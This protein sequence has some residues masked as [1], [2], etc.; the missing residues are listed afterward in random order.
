MKV[1]L[2]QVYPQLMYVRETMKNIVNLICLYSKKIL[3]MNQSDPDI[4]ITWFE[5]RGLAAL[6]QNLCI[7]LAAKLAI[8]KTILLHLSLE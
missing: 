6:V 2:K 8:F 3:F 4:Y 5:R 7:V 1:S